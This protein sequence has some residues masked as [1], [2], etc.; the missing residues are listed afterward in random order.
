MS[1]NDNIAR[2][3]VIV[4][5]GDASDGII[6]TVASTAAGGAPTAAKYI[7]QEAHADLSAEQSLGLLTTGIVK[8]T[9][10]AAVGVL[11]IAVG[12]DL[13]SH[14]HAGTDITSGLIPA[15]RMQEVLALADLSDV[16]AK[17]GT[18]TV[19][20]MATYPVITFQD[21]GLTIEDDGI[22]AKKIK[23]AL[24]G[25]PS[26]TTSIFPPTS[27]LLVGL[28]DSQTLTNKTLTSPVLTTPALG[29]PASGVL[30]NCTGLP[31]AGLTAPA[32]TITRIIYIENP[33]ATDDFPICFVADSATMV[34]VVAVTDVGTVD[35]NIEKRAKLTPDV[36][37]TNIW[38]V[39]KQAVAAGLDQTTFDS[40]GV[41]TSADEWLTFAAS[42]VA[43]SPTKLWVA[44][45][46][47]IN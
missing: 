32:R 26:A 9:T 36:A 12:A 21:T 25:M 5:N 2:G 28:D 42:A 8:N 31:P 10:T 38:T 46:Y 39:D 30:T 35:F 15:A 33:V 18:G 34:R 6:T 4:S 3:Q 45:E 23:F 43:S 37:G 1:D 13:P 41:A 24:G 27:G 40:G 29:T 44:L 22:S 14:A 16:T 47:T 17:T 11:S 19:V 20:A 7:V